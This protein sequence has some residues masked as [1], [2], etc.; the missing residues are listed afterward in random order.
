MTTTWKE[1]LAGSIPA[2]LGRELD[3]F[4][5]AM[6]AKRAGK[7]ENPVFAEMRLRRGIYG[8][9]YDNGQR[10][11]G[12]ETRTLEFPCGDLEKGPDTV[13]DAP[14]MMRIKIPWGGLDT[15]QLETMADL[16]EEYS[17][18]ILHITTRQ[19]VQLHFVQIDDTPDLMRRL[20]AVGITTREACGNS[21]RNVTACPRSGVCSTETFDVTP[22]AQATY[23]YVL[24]HPDTQNFGRKFKIAFS[25]CEGPS[26]G[27][28]RI[29]DVGCIAR[30][31][32]VDGKVERGF[33]F[34]V[35]GGLGAVPYQAE[36]FDEFLPEAGLLPTIQAIGRVFGRLGEKKNRARARLKFLTKKLGFD[37]FR[38]LVAEER[39]IL[40]PDPRWTSYLADLHG[41][42]DEPLHEPTAFEAGDYGKHF[43]DWRRNCVSAQ[44]Q[45]GYV[46]VNIALPLGDMTSAQTRAIADIVRRFTGDTCRA[47][48]EQNILLRWVNEGDLPALFEAL[49]AAGLARATA[50]TIADSTACPGTDTCKLGIA[51]S[52]G[53]VAELNDRLAERIDALDPDVAKLRIKASGCFNSCGQHHVA[54]IGFWGVSRKIRGEVVPHFQVALGG[55]WEGNGASYGLGIGAIPSKAVPKALDRILERYLADRDGKESFHDYTERIGKKEIRAQL[56]DLLEVP[57]FDDDPD[58]YF[59]W[60]D[61]RRFTIA[62]LGVGECAGEVVETTE[63]DLQASEREVFEAQDRLDKDDVEG[64]AEIAYRAMYLAAKA[65][66]RTQNPSTDENP[67]VVVDEFRTRLFDT[68]IFLDRYAGGKFA[69]YYFRAHEEVKSGMAQTADLARKRIEEAQ[70]FVD[71]AHACFGRMR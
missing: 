57:D 12:T 33:E 51:S 27:L 36:V 40:E 67:D 65:L 7:I 14:G 45:D 50:E 60:A 23:E 4:E 69:Q 32:E 55:Q 58:F 21:V 71:A 1:K 10:Y 3:S 41:Y 19:D 61:S 37:E 5:E 66:A 2:A 44:R 39:A 11:D 52:R 17:D 22:Y 24:G 34:Y 16:A 6:A 30:T 47:T 49:E 56:K 48:I 70:L 26:C 38:R 59:D 62:D 20:A 68:E 25:G 43:D 35:S 46:M 64:A 42:D 9:R 28:V 54:D 29:H 13:W 15:R 63:F 53:L 18:G 31:R 8:Q